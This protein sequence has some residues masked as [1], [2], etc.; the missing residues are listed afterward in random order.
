MQQLA[1]RWTRDEERVRD[2]HNNINSVE[3]DNLPDFEAFQHAARAL[4]CKDIWSTARNFWKKGARGKYGPIDLACAMASRCLSEHED[5]QIPTVITEAMRDTII[6]KFVNAEATLNDKAA[7]LKVAGHVFE[8]THALSAAA[9][10]TTYIQRLT[11]FMTGQA[12]NDW[13]T[14]YDRTKEMHEGELLR[15]AE[16]EAALAEVRAATAAATAAAANRG[17]KGGRGQGGKG[18]GS[19]PYSGKG[20]NKKVCFNYLQ[21]KCNGGQWCRFWHPANKQE[22]PE[23]ERTRLQAQHT[24]LTAKY[25]E[26]WGVTCTPMGDESKKEAAAA[27]S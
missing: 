9:A 26:W 3:L 27:A 8:Q 7:A 12:I 17:K 16:H 18:A 25:G 14:N 6:S 10:G 13:R 2:A 11:A 24:S 19:H 4:K 22:M 23:D 5:Q 21:S 15:K 20:K 1:G